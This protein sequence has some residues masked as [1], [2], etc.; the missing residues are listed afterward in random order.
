MNMFRGT[1]AVQNL[2][3]QG[4]IGRFRL[5]SDLILKDLKVRGRYGW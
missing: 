5:Y 1:K 2:V 4:F 3:L